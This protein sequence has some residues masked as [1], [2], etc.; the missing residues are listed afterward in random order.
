MVGVL[1]RAFR[2]LSSKQKG[3]VFPQLKAISV[4]AQALFGHLGQL[5]KVPSGFRSI[6]DTADGRNPFRST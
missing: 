2:G 1:N 5:D 3:V 6:E 4:S